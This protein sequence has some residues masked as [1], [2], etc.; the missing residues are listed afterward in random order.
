MSPE[1]WWFCHFSITNATDGTKL[2]DCGGGFQQQKFKL[3]RTFVRGTAAT[4]GKIVGAVA[5]RCRGVFISNVV[6]TVMEKD[7]E[8]HLFGCAIIG[9]QVCK[10]SL[11][12]ALTKSR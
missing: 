1:F 11:K 7:I 4:S 8:E 9:A 6:L 5:R 2:K 12:G 3:K 10:V